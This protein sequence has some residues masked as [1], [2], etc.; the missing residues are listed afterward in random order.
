MRG[1]VRIPERR[2]VGNHAHEMKVSGA[3]RLCL[4]QGYIYQDGL[5]GITMM[6]VSNK[7]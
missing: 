6:G 1:V 2:H 7:P 4:F 3:G 5:P